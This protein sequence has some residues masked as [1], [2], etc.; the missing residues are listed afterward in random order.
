[1]CN[2]GSKFC[3]SVFVT[4]VSVNLDLAKA[5]SPCLNDE[6]N[7]AIV[8]RLFL[9]ASV[10]TACPLRKQHDSIKRLLKKKYA[11]CCCRCCMASYLRGQNVL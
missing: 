8:K 7:Q 6:Q 5:C 10:A 4:C 2:G 1:M 9:T 11:T 3:A